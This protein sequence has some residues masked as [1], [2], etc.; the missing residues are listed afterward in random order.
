MKGGG[1][2]AGWVGDYVRVVR[3]MGC[4]WEASGDEGGWGRG[5][6][7]RGGDGAKEE[8]VGGEVIFKNIVIL[9]L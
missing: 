1:G 6:R 3:P 9:V 4:R 5:E 8:I 2:S 7:G